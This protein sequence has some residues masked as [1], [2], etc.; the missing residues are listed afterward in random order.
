[1]LITLAPV[2]G[3]LAGVVGV[4]DTVP[5]VRDIVRG[6]TRPHRGTWFIW[7]MLAV[8]VC[9]SQRADGASWSLVMAGTQAVLTS[10]IFVLAIR[11]GEGGLGATDGMLIAIAAGGMAAWVVVDEPVIATACVIA[12]D[13]IAA[14]MMVPKVYRDPG[15]ETLMTFALAGVGGALATGAV[16]ATDASL[17][18]YPIYYCLVN[19]AIALLIHYRRVALGVSP[20]LVGRRAIGA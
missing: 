13:L 10:L 4:V 19:W 7:G 18:C 2:F 12:A 3:V 8:V 17:L 14:A 11:R 16:G 5:Y 9:V 1:M 20:A 6:T 15:S